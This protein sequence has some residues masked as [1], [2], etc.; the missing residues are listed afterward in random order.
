MLRK[1]IEIARPQGLAARPIA[2]LVSVAS[3]FES[4][5]YLETENKRVNA[6]S[7]MGMMALDLGVGDSLTAEVDGTDEGAAM[8]EIE[9]FL[10]GRNI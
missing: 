3:R 9:Q 2:E 1:S 7:I 8:S 10:L 5:I 4:R 6:K